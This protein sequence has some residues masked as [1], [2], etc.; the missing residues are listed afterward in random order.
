[1]GSLRYC[2]HGLHQGC[3]VKAEQDYTNESY[4]TESFTARP[5]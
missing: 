1:M 5:T 3:E 2:Q 4:S